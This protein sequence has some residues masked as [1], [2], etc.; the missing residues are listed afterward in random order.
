MEKMAVRVTDRKKWILVTAQS[1]PT[2]KSSNAHLPLPTKLPMYP[3]KLLTKYW[4][5]YL[6][7]NWT[8]IRIL[9]PVEATNLTEQSRTHTI[10]L[11]MF[12]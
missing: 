9:N 7:T 6:K 12:A 1:H 3:D 4:T 2:P 5:K 10:S 11:E 8:N